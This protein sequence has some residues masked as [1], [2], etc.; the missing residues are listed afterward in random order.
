[1]KMS[2]RTPEMKVF[3]VLC[4]L[5]AL[6]CGADANSGQGGLTGTAGVSFTGAGAGAG[7]S[8][9]GSVGNVA[10]IGGTA[11]T[12]GASGVGAGAGDTAGV[13]AAGDGSPSCIPDATRYTDEILPLLQQ[14]CARCHTTPTQYGAPFTLLD[15]AAATSDYKGM[16]ISER[17]VAQLG[18]GSMPPAGNIRPTP[19][20]HDVIVDW[21]SCGMN[22]PVYP[23]ALK[24]NRA[25]FKAAAEPPASA[26]RIDLTAA[27]FPVANGTADLYQN[28]TFSNVVA[29]DKFVR[30]FDV[31]I[32][33]SRVV[34]H[35][36]L[37]YASG[38]AYLYAWA[39]GTGAVQFPEGGLRIKPTDQFRV[40][41]HYNNVSGEGDVVDSSGVTL[42]VD[43]PVGTEYA[44]KD[45]NTFA[46]FVPAAS[47]GSAQVNCTANSDFT[48]LAGM[49]HMHEI[50]E[51]YSHTLTHGD[52]TT[53]SIVDLSGW[54]FDLQFFY[55]FNVQVKAGDTMRITCNYFNDK[56]VVVT[57]G[58]G[59]KSE[60]CYDF[61]YVTPAS[62][63]LSCN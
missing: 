54:S 34:H 46:I 62:A 5:A 57:G 1:M 4:A 22:K 60:M 18:A 56:D 36:T 45:P 41:I 26:Q 61:M 25:I 51:S 16:R 13:G 35:I 40:E 44:M 28:F 15:Y 6:G 38:N 30:R 52:G 43:E 14:R 50:G 49:P 27:G 2:K 59:T 31:T 19:D 29:S 10:G 12:L 7:L 33:K 63:A 58:T 47:K 39:P 9:A 42:Y 3:A 20:E 48:I 21:A 55:E 8:A 53:E 11:G 17:M 23:T 24:S 32:D 37:H